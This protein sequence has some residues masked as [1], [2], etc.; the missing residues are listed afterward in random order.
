M[1]IKEL[2]LKHLEKNNW[3]KEIEKN[4]PKIKEEL[5]KIL[6][7]N[8]LVYAKK[9][10]GTIK[11]ISAFK[12]DSGKEFKHFKDYYIEGTSDNKK[13]KFKNAIEGVLKDELV[14]G[15]NIS[16]IEYNNKV[17]T[18]NKIKLG[19]DVIPIGSFCVIAGLILYIV[20]DQFLCITLGLIFAAIYGAVITHKK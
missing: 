8:G 13:E 9:S 12:N 7:N 17:I 18:Q 3:Y 4:N 10:F 11:Y 1:L 19:K 6:E 16:N 5:K 15:E 14:F 20:T 2:K